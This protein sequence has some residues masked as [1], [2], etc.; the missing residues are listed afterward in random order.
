MQ[1]REQAPQSR[2]RSSAKGLLCLLCAG[3]S[4][5]KSTDFFRWATTS[6]LR[7]QKTSLPYTTKKETRRSESLFLWE[8]RESNPRPSACKADALNQLSY[9]PET[10]LQIYGLFL[11]LQILF[12]RIAIFIRIDRIF[13]YLCSPIWKN[14]LVLTR[15]HSSVG[16]EHLPYKQRVGGSTPSA[17]TNAFSGFWGGIFRFLDLRISPVIYLRLW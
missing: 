4:N 2:R 11:N 9:A 1:K 6:K 13:A 8:Q 7:N 17:P 12:E 5:C 16:L 3:S 14:G 10:G 15:E